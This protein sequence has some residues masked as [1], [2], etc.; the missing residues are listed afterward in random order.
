[1]E[2]TFKPLMTAVFVVLALRMSAPAALPA[3]AERQTVDPLDPRLVAVLDGAAAYCKKLKNASLHFVCREQVEEWA[4]LGSVDGIPERI[5]TDLL[6][7]YQLVKDKGAVS[8]RRTLLMENGIRKEEKDA[9]LKTNRFYSV[10][11]VFGPIGFLGREW[12]EAYDFKL[13]KDGKVDGRKAYVIEARPKAKIEGKPNYG[14]LWVDQADFSILRIDIEQESLPGFE[15]V[16]RN[17][18]KENFTPAFTISHYFDIEKNGLRF[19]S[20]T[21]FDELYRKRVRGIKYR[22]PNQVALSKT[23]IL[24]RDYQ[25]FTVEIDVVFKSAI[26]QPERP[27]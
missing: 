10:K 12:R 1:M 11:G 16:A 6:Y 14:K 17:V 20:R 2:K 8:E 13:L 22:I 19:P 24:Y 3:P 27:L 23:T 18:Q 7:D 9:P 26:S 21:V 15:A 5:K 25:F 4:F